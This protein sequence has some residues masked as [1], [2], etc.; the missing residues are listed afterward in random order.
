MKQ[1]RAFVDAIEDDVARLLVGDDA[2][3]VPR[4]LLPADAVE[5]SWVSICVAVIPAP[6]IARSAA[7]ATQNFVIFDIG[8]STA[9]CCLKKASDFLTQL[10]KELKL[11]GN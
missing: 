10:Y 6:L 2:F 1:T 8:V 11:N 9:P 5:G 3:T 7:I 4:V